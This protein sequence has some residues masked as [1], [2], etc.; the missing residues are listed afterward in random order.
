MKNHQPHLVGVEETLRE[1]PGVLLLYL[2]TDEAGAMMIRDTGQVPDYVREQC[3]K[4][5]DWCATDY[6]GLVSG[7][8]A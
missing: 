3:E 1:R 6:R 2:L 5:L 4:A 7:A 8:K